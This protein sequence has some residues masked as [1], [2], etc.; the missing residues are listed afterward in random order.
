MFHLS[1]TSLIEQA[2]HTF[3]SENFNGAIEIM[4]SAFEEKDLSNE[5]L[6]NI[7]KGNIGYKEIDGANV[8]FGEEHIDQ[9]YKEELE[10]VLENY[11]YLYKINN[12]NFQLRK[13]LDFNLDLIANTNTFIDSLKSAQN[14][15]MPLSS[16]KYANELSEMC[17]ENNNT[18]FSDALYDQKQDGAAYYYY[19]DGSFYFFYKNDITV[20]KEISTFYDNVDA[21]I[22]DFDK[23]Q[24]LF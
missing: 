19:K 1:P 15:I 4:R 7:L 2:K 3:M 23:N 20:L 10:E 24:P 17:N 9:D 8:E 14:K 18:T 13:K 22:S 21:L 16:I 11:G 12:E 6:V 5:D